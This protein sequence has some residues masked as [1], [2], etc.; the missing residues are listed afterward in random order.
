MVGFEHP[1]NPVTVGEAVLL[2]GPPVTERVERLIDSAPPTM[3]FYERSIVTAD[4]GVY[5]SKNALPA[6]YTESN[7]P[8]FV[9]VQLLP[10]AQLG[11]GDSHHGVVFGQAAVSTPQGQSVINVA[12]KEFSTDSGFAGHEHDQLV[13]ARRLGFNTFEPLALARDGEN[14]YLITHKR[15]DLNTLDNDDW[16]ISPS[17][18]ERYESEVVPTLHFIAA[19]MATM[20]AKGL[21]HGDAQAKNFAR[22]DTGEFAVIDLE[23]AIVAETPE[24]TVGFINSNWEVHQSKAYMDVTHCWYALVHPMGNENANN[25]FLEGEPFEIC[26]E[27]FETNIL[28]PYFAALEVQMGPEEF[29]KVNV[30]ELRMAII[31]RTAATT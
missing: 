29:A 27:Q 2:A 20:H 21:F 11:A 3:G 24:D 25:V 18:T 17:D 15:E 6:G 8:Q 30:D 14:T 16:T 5:I 19:N 13:A 28:N 7:L 4:N 10:G 1:S 23:E 31:Q 9:D 26:M 22:T 12:V